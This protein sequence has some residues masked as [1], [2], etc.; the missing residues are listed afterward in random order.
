VFAKI[1]TKP[2]IAFFTTG[3][4]NLRLLSVLSISTALTLSACGGGSG[5]SADVID[6][7]AA[8]DTIETVD[9]TADTPISGTSPADAPAS[10]IPATDTPGDITP[11]DFPPATD[12]PA[13]TDPNDT[14]IDTPTQGTPPPATGADDEINFIGVIDIDIDRQEALGLF[15]QTATSFTASQ[16]PEGVSTTMDTCQVIS[17]DV[18]AT[19][20]L[21]PPLTPLEASL[22]EVEEETLF[23]VNAGEVITLTSPAGSFGE[24]VLDSSEPD[25]FVYEEASDLP[26]G[27]IPAGTTINIPGSTFPGV[28]NV[29]VPAV[30]LL[31][32][33]SPANGVTLQGVEFTWTASNNTATNLINFGIQTQ[34]SLISCF[35]VDDGSFTV[36]A[37]IINE[38]GDGSFLTF[39][40]RIGQ[41]VTI[42]NNAIVVVIASTGAQI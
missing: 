30:P 13:E 10:E 19:D 35:L 34:T 9:P 5:S 2:R 15:D 41:T 17:F 29:P 40:S 31:T 23:P 12:I 36:P 20:E 28:A 16:I 3:I 38:A 26:S 1:K 42:S 22:P 21:G 4:R 6:T 7:D 37:D 8:A 24:L 27:G 39:P 14:P 33:F 32:D 11:P 25:E 18:D